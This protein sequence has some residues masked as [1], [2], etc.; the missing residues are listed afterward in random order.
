MAGD[1]TNANLSAAGMNYRKLL[2]FLEELLRQIFCWFSLLFDKPVC[3][4]ISNFG[5]F[6]IDQLLIS[7]L[8]SRHVLY[9]VHG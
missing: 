1:R 4:D 8:I 2:R 3:Y 6:R 9:S 7:A 5:F